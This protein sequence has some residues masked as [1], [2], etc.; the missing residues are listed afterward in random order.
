MDWRRLGKAGKQ[1]RLH[2]IAKWSVQFGLNYEHISNP[3]DGMEGQE[4]HSA[5]FLALA[6]MPHFFMKLPFVP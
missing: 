3:A 6:G 4:G 1:I 5:W 2:F